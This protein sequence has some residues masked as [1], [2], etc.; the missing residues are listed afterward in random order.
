MGRTWHVKFQLPITNDKK[1]RVAAEKEY[2]TKFVEVFTKIYEI[3]VVANFMTPLFVRHCLSQVITEGK[4]EQ[5]EMRFTKRLSEL[6][7]GDNDLEY[8]MD[9]FMQLFEMKP[10]PTPAPTARRQTSNSRNSIADEALRPK[11]DS[12]YNHDGS[13]NLEAA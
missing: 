6:L 11:L 12:F 7:P 8:R 2:Y 5:T 10:D 9:N 4:V 3:K 1:V 13:I